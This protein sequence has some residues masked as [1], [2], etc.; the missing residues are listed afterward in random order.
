MSDDVN[1]L[2][3]TLDRAF[4]MIAL[5]DVRRTGWVLRGVHRPESVADHSWGTALLAL[6]FLADARRSEGP[7]EGERVLAIAV[8][9][10]LAEV[11]TGDIPRRVDPSRQPLG[12]ADKAEAERRALAELV[13]TGRPLS[14]LRELWEEYEAAATPEARYVR[15]MNLVDMCLQALRYEIEKRYDPADGAE[16]F[17]EY[18]RMEEFFATAGPRFCTAVGRQMYDRLWNRYRRIAGEEAGNRTS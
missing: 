1:T 4:E 7:L 13:G 11:R 5:K 15:D 9:H 10:D 12:E 18:R 16:E 3:D 14:E 2:D 8:I 6:L 17:P